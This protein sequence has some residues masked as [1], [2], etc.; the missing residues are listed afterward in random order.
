MKIVWFFFLVLLT[1]TSCGD[2][3]HPL[4]ENAGGSF[5]LALDN[6]PA[7]YIPRDVNDVYSAD[8]LG[9]V[10][11]CLVSLD[12][13]D[14][15]V[16]PQL[17]SS[18][19]VSPDGL[20]YEFKLRKGVMFH[21]H[22]A[23]GSD[24][25]R[26]VTTEDVKK[27][28]ELICSKNETGA[29]GTAYSFLFE[30]YLKGAEAFFKKEAKSISGL[31]TDDNKITFQLVEPDNN[32]LNKLANISCA[33]VSQKVH[34]ANLDQDMIGTG[35]F[36][37]RE[38]SKNET[39]SIILIKN[40]EYY[41]T[42]EK[43]CALP[44]LDSVVFVLESRKLEQLDLF[45]QKK[46]DLIMGLPSSRITKMLEER[47]SDYNS[48]P[49]V[50]I[51]Q[52]NPILT[53]NYYFFNMQDE[54]FKKLKV[55][56]AFN[57]AI[58]KQKIGAEILR[59]QYYE[60]GIYGIVPPVSS[61]F[62]GYDFAGIDSVGYKYNP[63]KAR[64]LFEEAG[65]PGGQGFGSIDLRFNI[66]D[67]NSAVADEVAQQLNQVLGI[68]VNIDGSTFDQLEKDAQLG[69]SALFRS[70]WVADYPSPETFLFNFY[71]KAVPRNKKTPSIINKSRYQNAEF[72]NLFEQAKKSNKL[73]DQMLY[74]AK[75]EKVLM[76]DPPLI[77]LWYKADFDIIY[78]NIRNFHFNSLNLMS[79][80][81]VYKKEWT[82]AEYLE[83]MK[84]KK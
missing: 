39:N 64:Q 24:D 83:E 65:Y 60:L 16:T 44:Y 18:W 49:P 55:R 84:H 48:T 81:K 20:T 53:T 54:R 12:P 9:Q 62:R 52:N 13:K 5:Y 34:E 2:S 79:F 50:L 56:Q 6:E 36:M 72:D 29:A 42:D 40:E 7:T 17:A 33:I 46:L 41:L 47:I 38:Y 4:S 11:E 59:N 68:N 75:A 63:E 43:G 51:L 77:P 26:L 45:E 71:G 30:K 66:N 15:K 28:I 70:A 69:K 61:T 1:L 10:M 23:F 37:F 76:Q 21:P 57:Y 74:F 22:S 25:D 31:K 78:P 82:K 67:V 27:T 73:S 58:N 35:P 3:G 19:K 32:F 8:V 14:L 80:A